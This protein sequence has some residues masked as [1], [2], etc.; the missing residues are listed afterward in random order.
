MTVIEILFSSEADVSVAALFLFKIFT[1]LPESPNLISAAPVS[2]KFTVKLS[3]LE[4]YFYNWSL[5]SKTSLEASLVPLVEIK[6][7]TLD[8]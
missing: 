6:L 3:V 8:N 5:G 4:S 1:P 2:S 7:L